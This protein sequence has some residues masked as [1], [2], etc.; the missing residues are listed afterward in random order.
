[1]LH[2]TTSPNLLPSNYSI[3]PTVAPQEL[4]EASQGQSPHRNYPVMYR[5]D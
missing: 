4:A 2:H 5:A 1:M 3:D